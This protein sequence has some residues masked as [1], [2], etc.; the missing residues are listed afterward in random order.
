V[1]NPSAVQFNEEEG[2]V[3]ISGL[4]LPQMIAIFNGIK[5]MMCEPIV[6]P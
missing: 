1:S 4:F 2:L 3:A 5:Q 6:I